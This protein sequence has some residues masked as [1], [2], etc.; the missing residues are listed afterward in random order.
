MH[1]A[2]IY[3]TSLI[4]GV[5]AVYGLV[6]LV[7]NVPPTRQ[8]VATFLLLVV[9]AAVGLLGPALAWLHRRVP[10]GGRPPTRRAAFRQ[11]LLVGLALALAAWLQLVGL[12]DPTLVLGITALVV[13]VELLVQSR[14]KPI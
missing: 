6:S 9:I 3:G 13:L 8:N 4:A 11:A 7:L 1:D 5:G 14:R 12:L 2:L 10:I